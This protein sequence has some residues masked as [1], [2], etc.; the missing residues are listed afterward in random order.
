MWIRWIRIR[1]P[2]FYE[3]LTK[4]DSHLGFTGYT[5][6]CDGFKNHELM[7]KVESFV[8]SSCPLYFKRNFLRTANKKRSLILGPHHCM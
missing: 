3:L 5:T 8:T 6:A 4:Q 1:N 7:G 2:A